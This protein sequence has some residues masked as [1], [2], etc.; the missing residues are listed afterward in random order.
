MDLLQS[1]IALDTVPGADV[2]RKENKKIRREKEG[3]EAGFKAKT[4]M[5]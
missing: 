3:W 1:A 4:G 5:K 2:R